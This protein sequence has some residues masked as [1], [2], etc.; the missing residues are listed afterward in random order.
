MWNVLAR[1]ELS[2]GACGST[3]VHGDGGRRRAERSGARARGLL[4]ALVRARSRRELD[5][6]YL[7]GVI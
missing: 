6:D 4:R 5:L 2:T 7:G 3:T 1:H